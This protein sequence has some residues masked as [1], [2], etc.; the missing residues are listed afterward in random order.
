MKRLLA[1]FG[2]GQF[3]RLGHGS[4]SNEL[5]PRVVSALTGI[6][7]TAVAAGGAHTA[8]V[9][10]DGGLWTFGINSHGQLGYGSELPHSVEPVEAILPDA[11]TAVAAGES[12][13][14]ALSGKQELFNNSNCNSIPSHAVALTPAT[15]GTA[16]SGTATKGIDAT[17]NTNA[18]ND[19]E[20]AKYNTVKLN[21]LRM[22]AI[23]SGEVWAAGCNADGQL[24]L[25]A[26]FG[27][28]N[29]EFRLVKALQGVRIK[30]VAA[31][32]Q[33]SLA[34]SEDGQVYSWGHGHYGALGLGPTHLRW[35]QQPLP[36]TLQTGIKAAAIAVGAYHSGAVDED[37][38][39]WLWGHGGSW[40]LGLGVNTHE[41]IPQQLPSLRHVQQLCLGFSHSMA[42][43]RYGD[44]HS[45]GTD[46]HGSLGQGFRWPK[47]GSQTPERIPVRLQYG[48]AGWKH[49][50]GVNSDGRLFT[51]GWAGAVGGGGLVAGPSYDLG[52]GQLGLG[53]DMDQYEPQQVQR[54]LFGRNR[55]RDLRQSLG[56]R[57]WHAM[58]VDSQ[59]GDDS[60]ANEFFMYVFKASGGALGAGAHDWS[61]CPY[62]H[63]KEKA[64]RRDPRVYQYASTPCP[65]SLKGINCGRGLA[66][67]YAHSVYEYW[68]HPARFRTQM[69]KKEV[70]RGVPDEYS[71]AA[72]NSNA[73]RAM[74]QLSVPGANVMG[75]LNAG[76]ARG[77]DSSADHVAAGFAGLNLQASA[78]GMGLMVPPGGP[79]SSQA[80]A[81]AGSARAEDLMLLQQN[82]LRASTTG[83]M[84]NGMQH[85]GGL[86]T[87]LPP[88]LQPHVAQVGGSTW[89]RIG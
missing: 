59:G 26:S 75:I 31:G 46:E 69:C 43:G 32:N 1:T 34:L 84:S 58:Q 67:P 8:A 79:G 57:P 50:A 63:P 72:I 45:W 66:C 62:A 55:F 39:A 25:G 11:M 53:D 40:Q 20:I 23:T 42:I 7:V 21:F 71:G 16:T 85:S 13:T 68:L 78:T 56:G 28:R 74:Q 30:A 83:S 15:N 44:V 89:L 64:R 6:K 81:R 77:V 61:S 10:E 14:L 73:A 48:A 51:W 12:H 86:P 35:V 3:G 38:A 65:E 27:I 17:N 9:A 24:G 41:C 5:F 88:E 4:E 82:L 22:C 70:G 60:V 54:L 19:T 33:H 18:T 76:R 80:P 87:V 2:N 36:V 47:P 37:G 49:T 29:A 52:A